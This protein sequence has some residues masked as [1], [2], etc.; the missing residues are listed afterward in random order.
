M[1]TQ[2]HT[3]HT[4]THGLEVVLCNYTLVYIPDIHA[5]KNLQHFNLWIC[6]LF[7]WQKWIWKEKRQILQIN[8]AFKNDISSISVLQFVPALTDFLLIFSLLSVPG[9]IFWADDIN[10]GPFLACTHTH[11]FTICQGMQTQRDEIKPIYCLK[12][13]CNG[14]N[15]K[16]NINM[17]TLNIK[18]CPTV[19]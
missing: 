11:N 5:V 12:E 19:D 6:L 16:C 8:W 1:H 14:L 3:E 17:C 9:T 13:N 10:R 18:P 7:T 4:S 2:T 15:E